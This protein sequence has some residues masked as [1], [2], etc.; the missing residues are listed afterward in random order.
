MFTEKT[1]HWTTGAIFLVD[2]L[3]TDGEKKNVNNTS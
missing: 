1:L 2:K 3:F